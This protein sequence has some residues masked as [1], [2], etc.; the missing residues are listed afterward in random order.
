[1]GVKIAHDGII[2]QQLS[3]YGVRVMNRPTYFEILGEDPRKL[4]EFYEAVF[5][6][7]AATWGGEE[8]AYFT[9]TTGPESTPGINGGLM[10]RH[11]KQ[12]VI[13]THDVGNLEAAL[14][15]IKAAGGKLVHGP[16]EVPEVGMHCYCEDPQGNMFGILEG[17]DR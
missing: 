7:K 17:F 12:N 13:N 8:Q 11:F 9:V 2:G 6:W 15:K 4:G 10:K 3:D 14:E 1:M 5:G 16:N